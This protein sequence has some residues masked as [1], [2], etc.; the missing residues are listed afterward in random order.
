M[1]FRQ[2]L[3]KLAIEDSHHPRYA[4]AALIAK[5]KSI[6]AEGAN[7]A[8]IHAEAD[9]LRTAEGCG[10]D[11]SGATMYTLMVRRR[12]GSLGDGS[13]CKE[14]MDLIRA[15]KLRRVVVYL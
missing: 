1:R 14:C 11:I 7:F 8:G 12:S 6:L 10:A 2:H 4:H 13:P 3:I 15:A 5:G 9:A